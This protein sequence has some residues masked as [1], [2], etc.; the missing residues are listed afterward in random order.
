MAADDEGHLVCGQSAFS[1]DRCGDAVSFSLPKGGNATDAGKRKGIGRKSRGNSCQRKHPAEILALGPSCASH[2][3]SSN[4]NSLGGQHST[5]KLE[6]CATFQWIICAAV[7]EFESYMPS[8]AVA[9]LWARQ[10]SW[11]ELR[12]KSPLG[13][14]SERASSS[15]ATFA[16]IS[17]NCVAGRD[18][19]RGIACAF[20]M[21]VHWGC[22]DSVVADYRRIPSGSRG[23]PI[24]A[25]TDLNAQPVV[26][27][28]K[29][30]FR[31][32]S[33]NPA[34]AVD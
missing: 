9:S 27:P 30:V 1:G 6:I 29:R 5:R 23:G 3:R 33:Q 34:G 15:R 18:Q 21:P 26:L 24:C 25:P 16:M 31:S 10:A 4:A 20:G 2:R 13:P 22:N 28:E 32:L 7:S 11:I 8:H 17:A 19:G 14:W 12:F